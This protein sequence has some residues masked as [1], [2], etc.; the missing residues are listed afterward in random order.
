M[1]HSLPLAILFVLRVDVCDSA[2][3]IDCLFVLVHE[4]KLLVAA[5]LPEIVKVPLRH[6]P[7][8]AAALIVRTMV[9]L[10]VEILILEVPDLLHALLIVRVEVHRH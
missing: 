8:L 2:P 6:R 7:I 1:A 9:L 4:D 10:F 3:H 5:V